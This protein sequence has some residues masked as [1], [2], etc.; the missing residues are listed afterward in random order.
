MQFDIEYDRMK[1]PT[2]LHFNNMFMHSSQ[3]NEDSVFISYDKNTMLLS[4]ILTLFC[5]TMR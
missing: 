4:A 3:E 1:L 5:G 2:K